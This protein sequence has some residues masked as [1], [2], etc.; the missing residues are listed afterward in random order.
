MAST[1]ST[2]QPRLVIRRPERRHSSST[3][4]RRVRRAARAAAARPPRVAATA[5]PQAS[6]AS[7]TGV[8]GRSSRWLRT[9]VAPHPA[10]TPTGSARTSR[11]S[12]SDNPKSAVD[13]APRPRSLARA[14][15]APRPS[16]ASVTAR[17]SSSRHR[18]SSCRVMSRMGMASE[19]QPDCTDDS[20]AG[21]DVLTRICCVGQLWILAE[22]GHRRAQLSHIPASDPVRAQHFVHDRAALGPRG[23]VLNSGQRGEHR[24]DRRGFLR[25]ALPALLAVRR[26]VVPEPVI[27]VRVRHLIDAGDGQRHLACQVQLLAD[28][29]VGQLGRGLADQDLAR[30]GRAFPVDPQVRAHRRPPDQ[31]DGRVVLRQRQVALQRVHGRAEQPAPGQAA[32]RAVQL[33]FLG[34]GQLGV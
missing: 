34:R 18:A 30:R 9:A 17:N 13:Q 19:R 22:G 33:R 14:I 1:A 6:P 26:G 27:R 23:A 31:R 11:I 15:S 4:R 3:G 25:G 28:V 32:E 24:L 21:M 10:S 20:V 12:G 2:T 5:A 29:P 16:T 8:P 7:S